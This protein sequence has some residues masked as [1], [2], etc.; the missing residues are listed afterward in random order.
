M[1]EDFF[2]K[3]KINSE[4]K[5]VITFNEVFYYD[6]TRNVYFYHYDFITSRYVDFNVLCQIQNE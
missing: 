2:Y 3:R 1:A 5:D 6:K 4:A